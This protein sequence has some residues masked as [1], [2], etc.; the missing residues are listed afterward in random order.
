[1]AAKP[2]KRA[3]LTRTLVPGV[4][5]LEQAYTNCYLI[6]DTTGV[7]IVD[8]AFPKT[9]RHLLSALDAIGR[10]RADVKAVVLT[11]GHF[12][13][14]GFATIAIEELGVPVWV[15]PGDQRL[16]AH[17]YRY[18]RE[19]TPLRY[20]FRYPAA[21]R[22]LGAM[23]TVG[24]LA[25]EGV[26]SVRL[27]PS[28]G[29]VDVPGQPQVVHAPGHTSGSCALHLREQGVLFTGDALVT[30]DPYKAT[31]GPQIVAGAATADSALA[32][33]SLQALAATEA[34]LVL[35]GH[36]DPW[37]AGIRSAV[38]QAVVAGIS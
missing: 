11:H 24:A 37:H 19:R 6:E 5:R 30:F 9:W 22:A 4:H 8:A 21:M 31:T 16:A 12:D 34:Q 7:T 18:T 2:G 26:E 1:M 13:H 33:S 29:V 3:T 20:P 10:D 14:V 15:H 38:A 35:P 17:P 28:S 32:L 27:L 23:V 25:V 36:G